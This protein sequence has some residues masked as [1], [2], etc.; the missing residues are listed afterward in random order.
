M[1]IFPNYNIRESAF[2]T[3]KA[4]KDGCPRLDA[5]GGTLMKDYSEFPG[6][7]K[8]KFN[9]CY[10]TKA[11]AGF[12]PSKGGLDTPLQSILVICMSLLLHSS[13]S[14]EMDLLIIVL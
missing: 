1:C 12:D 6:A 11:F 3:W 4:P 14:L 9:P 8:D 2:P 10:Y 5:L 13:S 7:E